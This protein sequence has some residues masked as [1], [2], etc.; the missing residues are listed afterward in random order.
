MS[1]TRR[2]T[3][4]RENLRGIISLTACQFLFLINDTQVKLAGDE[5]PL[6]QILF[7]RGFFATILLA[8]IVF[9]TGAHR[10]A[11]LVLHR[12]MFWRTGT[13]MA[14]A[15][16][17]LGALFHMPIANANA[18]AQVVPLM[19]TA[20]A[21]IFLGERVGW[22]R[23]LAIMIG[24]IGVLVVIRPGLEGFNNWSLLTLASMAFVTIRDLIT[25]TMPHGIPNLLVSIVTAIA[26]GLSGVIYGLLIGEAWMWP[27]QHALLLTAGAGLFLLGGY[28]TSVDVMRH[29]DISVTA[30][31]RYSVVLWAIIVGFVVW[32]EIPD[33]PMIIGTTII[34][35]TGL[36]TFHRERR[37]ARMAAEPV[38][39]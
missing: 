22:R 13:E 4:F 20:S 36:Y 7:M 19:I 30:P 33:A 27:S 23:W 34:I 24:F 12:G 9:L 18:I 38:D 31:F 32:G 8:P 17:F 5:L 26:V 1:R 6:G 25:R 29:G 21:A 10:Q 15:Y 14:A 16:L 35:A 28:L 37:L 2:P 11:R 3:P 39:I